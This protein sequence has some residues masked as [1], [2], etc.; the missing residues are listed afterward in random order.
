[1]EPGRG[2]QGLSRCP[3]NALFPNL[4][5]RYGSVQFMIIHFSLQSVINILLFCACQI[6]NLK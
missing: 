5:G 1:M 4:S 6:L 2:K 3:G